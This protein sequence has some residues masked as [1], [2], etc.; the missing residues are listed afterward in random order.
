MILKILYFLSCFSLY[1]CGCVKGSTNPVIDKGIK[2]V[3]QTYPDDNIVEEG[4][5]DWI[6]EKTTMQ[7]DFSPD[8]PEK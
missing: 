2:I 5:E 3:D 7:F 8:T 4:I 6:E 1:A